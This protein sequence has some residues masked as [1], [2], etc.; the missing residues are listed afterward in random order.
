MRLIDVIV[1]DD[2]RQEINGKL[3][4]IGVYSGSVVI[5]GL[6]TVLPTFTLVCKWATKDTVVP[7]GSYEV[8]SPRGMSLHRIET[9]DFGS[10]VP[11]S[12]EAKDATLKAK[13]N[14]ALA[15]LQFRPFTFSEVGCYRLTFRPNEGR[16]RVL[17]EFVVELQKSAGTV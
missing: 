5:F 12:I 16:S 11:N 17:K 1:C 9:R 10:Q 7:P 4:L 8:L 3:L 15:I 14:F 2:V 6:P 13:S